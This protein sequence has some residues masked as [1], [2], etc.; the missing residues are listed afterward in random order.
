MTLFSFLFQFFAQ[1]RFDTYSNLVHGNGS[2]GGDG[3]T[4]IIMIVIGFFIF[5][6]IFKRKPN[7]M[8]KV[9]GICWIIFCIYY[10]IM[11]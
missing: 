7:K 10:L 2:S 1:N 4:V 5:K 8:R 11:P 3:I 6:P 9:L